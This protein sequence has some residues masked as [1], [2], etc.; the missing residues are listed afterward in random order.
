MLVVE[1]AV[2]TTQPPATKF[3]SLCRTAACPARLLRALFVT[4]LVCLAVILVSPADLSAADSK[5]DLTDSEK[6]WIDAHPLIRVG[7]DGGYAPYSFVNDKGEFIGLAP[8]ILKLISKMTGLQL[9][10]VPDLSWPQ[11]LNGAQ[12][13]T[14]DIIATAVRT[15]ER[16][17][18]LSFTDIYIPTPLVIMNRRGDHRVLR[19]SDLSGKTV[20]LVDS[21][22]SSRRV[23]EEY[24]DIIVKFVPD[25]LAGLQAVALGEADAYVGV[26]GVNAYLAKENGLTNLQV[27]ARYDLSTNGQRIG[28]RRDWPELTSI[29]QKTLEQIGIPEKS[30]IFERWVPVLGAGNDLNQP[31]AFVLTEK[32][33]AWLSE[34]NEIRVGV[35]NAWPPLDFVDQ[36]GE[37]KGIGVEFLRAINRRLGGIVRPV[38]G[39][40]NDIF[41][42][43]K[44]GKLDALTGITPRE[45]RGEFFNFT[46]PYVNIPHAIFARPDEPFLNNLEDLGDKRV[47]TEAGFF[48]N[49]V[50]AS[51]FPG[52][53]LITFPS[54]AEALNAVSTGQVDAY[55]GNRAVATFIILNQLI[56]GVQ[57]HGLINET[58]SINA[59]GVRKNAPILRGILQKALDSMTIRERRLILDDWV[60]LEDANKRSFELSQAEKDWLVDHAVIRVA[61][62]RA[63]A[64]I[65]FIGKDGEFEG[66]AVEFL[67]R[68]S[69]LLD[70]RFEF[71]R[72]SN[73]GTVVEKVQTRQLDMFS[74]AASTSIRRTYADF[75]APYI[76]LPAM[77]FSRRNA[78]PASS[79]ASLKNRRVAVIKGYAVTEFLISSNWDFI[80]VQVATVREALDM[81]EAQEVDAYIGSILVT[82][83]FIRETGYTNIVVTGQSPYAINL[84]MGV[85]NDWPLFTNILRRAVNHISDAERAAVFGKWI[86]LEVKEPPDYRTL[87]IISFLLSLVMLAAAI[88]IWS[89]R[90]VTQTQANELASRNEALIHEVQERTLAEL[91]A[92][93][94]SQAK[95]SLLANMSHEFR[96]PLNAIIGYCEM[97]RKGIGVEKPKGVVRNYLD[98]I[99]GAGGHMLSLITDLLDISAIEQNN[100]QMEEEW[101]SLEYLFGQARSLT[102]TNSKSAGITTQWASGGDVQIYA[103]QRRVLQIL[104]NLV[105]N[106]LKFSPKGSTVKTEV[107]VDQDGKL[108]IS[109]IDEG[110]GMHA[111][112]IARLLQPFN[113][114]ET[115]YVRS[116]Q[117]AGLGLSLANMLATTHD[118]HLDIVSTI[119]VGTTISLSLPADRVRS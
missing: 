10:M 104:L 23:L 9:K 20:A 71:D 115:P 68:L 53:N 70:V 83:F 58:S 86:G 42:Q 29:L 18:Y 76:N 13:R 43:V 35:N 51:S 12:D 114:G 6:A 63:F 33:A 111:E 45:N 117:G 92:H 69:E 30:S 56:D 37:A 95:S 101:F 31:V 60:A 82:G 55:I 61:G 19:T 17:E 34:Q 3:R 79:M 93:E 27:A 88:W 94:A 8:D 2:E 36:N 102:H 89:L 52:I 25:P 16:T 77:I 96:T 113:R 38:P 21:Y 118:G 80:P 67:N 47:G 66:V 90:S 99:H 112:Q 98:D 49:D 108:A 73:W 57:Q 14:I 116:T 110:H 78:Y 85:R 91:V 11:I 81:L 1:L 48:I 54:T 40:W 87:L 22:S 59:I 75:T 28:V 62:D 46:R 107:K 97:L 109:V 50:I 26:L 65:E 72:N 41:E 103:D 5:L 15:D 4:I 106:A 39:E 74:A 7:V 64:P 84:A 105:D 32:E 44:E 24:P 100:I 119:D